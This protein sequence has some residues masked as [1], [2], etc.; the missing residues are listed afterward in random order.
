MKSILEY[1]SAYSIMENLEKAKKELNKKLK[2]TGYEIYID[3]DKSNT[4]IIS[5]DELVDNGKEY[6]DIQK[7]INSI[8]KKYKLKKDK[9]SNDEVVFLSESINESSNISIS[10]KK[11]RSALKDVA[12]LLGNN[13]DKKDALLQTV[14]QFFQGNNYVILEDDNWNELDNYASHKALN[15][16]FSIAKIFKED[17]EIPSGV[18]DEFKTVIEELEAVDNELLDSII[19]SNLVKVEESGENY[20]FSREPLNY[21]NFMHGAKGTNLLAKNEL[22]KWWKKQGTPEEQQKR[23]LDAIMKVQH[24]LYTNYYLGH[25]GRQYIQ[26]NSYT[27]SMTDDGKGRIIQNN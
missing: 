3:D 20:M 25:P 4:L 23:C 24:S 27:A 8:S 21:P 9:M 1:N 11:F 10:S 2:A 14:K 6:T 13:P 5:V 26:D 18:S 17:K 16:I 7:H 12:K 19:N 15:D 22:V